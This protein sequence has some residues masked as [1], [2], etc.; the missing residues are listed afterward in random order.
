MKTPFSL[1]IIRSAIFVLALAV[2]ISAHAANNSTNTPAAKKKEK[3][4]VAST[5][6]GNAVA[7]LDQAYGLLSRADHDYDGHRVHAMH[8]IEAAAKEL[9]SKLGGHGKGDEKQT[10][11]D[12]QL[13]SAESLL[14]QAVGDVKGKA[15]HHVKEALKQLH[16]A[17]HIK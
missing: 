15:H 7:L 6:S 16:I 9:G 8:A 4:A 1:F 14:S 12:A 13:T 17:L 11:S 10:T 3:A 5:A 2:G